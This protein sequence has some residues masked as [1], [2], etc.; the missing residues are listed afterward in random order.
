M[1]AARSRA[2]HQ[3]DIAPC[4]DEAAAIERAHLGLIYRGGSKL[5][6]VEVLVDRELGDPQAILDAPGSALGK[7][8]FKEVEQYPLRSMASLYA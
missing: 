1:Q 7:F 3:E 5:K 4:G 8:R 6:T 2:S